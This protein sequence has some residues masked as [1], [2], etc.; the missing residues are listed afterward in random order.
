MHTI[1]HD[2]NMTLR[3]R[4]IKHSLHVHSHARFPTLT[5]R[6]LYARWAWPH[7]PHV[8]VHVHA[9]LVFTTIV[10]T[11]PC[12]V[13]NYRLLMCM[14]MYMQLACYTSIQPYNDHVQPSTHVHVHAC[15]ACI[16]IAAMQAWCVAIATVVRYGE[17]F[18]PSGTTQPQVIA[19]CHGNR[20]LWTPCDVAIIA[21]TL[22]YVCSAHF[23]NLRILYI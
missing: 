1:L 9:L 13:H 3:A 15:T 16:H 4:Q 17:L 10:A 14:Y 23:T 5:T 8:H 11:E 6:Q 18:G 21:L 12:N 2:C 7:S 20:P 22:A 19:E